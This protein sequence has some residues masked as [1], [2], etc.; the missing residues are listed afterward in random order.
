[1]GLSRSR[2]NA[3]ARPKKNDGFGWNRIRFVSLK[4]SSPAP[5]RPRMHTPAMSFTKKVVG[6]WSRGCGHAEWPAFWFTARR[7]GT[8]CG[9]SR[10][11]PASR[12][13]SDPHTG[14]AQ[15]STA[16]P[17]HP[18]AAVSTMVNWSCPGRV[19]WEQR[20]VEASPAEENVMYTTECAI[21]CINESLINHQHISA[22][23][24]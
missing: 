5:R 3:A 21:S 22:S 2:G 6:H 10:Y 9:G 14:S 23:M 8:D 1:M 7:C 16:L 19:W 15:S 4:R 24:N 20:R 17:G 12:D 13:S 11:R 18:L